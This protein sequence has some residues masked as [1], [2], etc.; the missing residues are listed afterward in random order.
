M[1]QSDIRPEPSLISYR[2]SSLPE[3]SGPDDVG[4]YRTR[5][6]RAD[7]RTLN[8]RSEHVHRVLVDD[9]MKS[10]VA[11]STHSELMPPK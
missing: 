1:T 9:P 11:G 4:S 6:R 2:A 7:L 8:A 3:V 5:D 10:E